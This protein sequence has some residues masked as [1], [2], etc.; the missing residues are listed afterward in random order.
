[1]SDQP[2][3]PGDAREE[4]RRIAAHEPDERGP[5]GEDEAGV[6]AEGGDADVDDNPLTRG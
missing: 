1:M 3:E 4:E 2:I 5:G 6:P